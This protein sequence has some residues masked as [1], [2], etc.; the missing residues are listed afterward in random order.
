MRINR[1]LLYRIMQVFTVTN[2]VLEKF[3]ADL[4]SISLYFPELVFHT[5]YHLQAAAIVIAVSTVNLYLNE[6]RDT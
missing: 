1:L 5:L 6:I 4:I 2:N 3:D